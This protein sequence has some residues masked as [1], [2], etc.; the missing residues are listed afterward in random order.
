MKKV[1]IPTLAV[2]GIALLTPLGLGFIVKNKYVQLYQLASESTLPVKL[3]MVEYSQGWFSSDA[4]VQV[5]LEAPVTQE[6]EEPAHQLKNYQFELKQ[7]IYHGPII[8]QGINRITFALAL[9]DIIINQADLKLDLMT[10]LHYNNSASIH[11]E[12]PRVAETI[13]PERGWKFAMQAL[14][15]NL[16][17]NAQVTHA[18][19]KIDLTS[20]DLILKDSEQHF[21]NARFI[22]NID[23]DQLNLWHGKR[24]LTIATMS[25]D[26]EANEQL[27]VQ[28]VTL[29]LHDLS[30]NNKFSTTLYAN[31]AD[32]KLDDTD[33]GSQQVSLHVDNVDANALNKI[34]TK[35]AEL[36]KK[37]LPTSAMVLE[38]FPLVTELVEKGFSIQVSPLALNT[39]WGAIT[40]ELSL[41]IPENN[42]TNPS[43][44]ALLN[45]IT[46]DA[47]IKFPASLLQDLLVM[48]Y[49]NN[50]TP[51]TPPLNA[52]AKAAAIDDIKR[53]QL[54]GWLLA[55][56]DQFTAQ[57][58]FKENQLQINGKMMK[59]PALSI[60]AATHEPDKVMH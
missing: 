15:G 40:G 9:S 32:V 29:G 7:K 36:E 49:Q 44:D 12:C 59:I 26:T 60:S 1:V 48:R 38:L 52:D 28:G 54:A 16:K 25:F 50:N 33:Y 41:N 30:I 47:K 35:A 11:F 3:Q 19:G 21:K 13:D 18:E 27:A 31:I 45:N 42:Q 5:T 4:I 34:G 17:I 46:A 37:N 56:G 58:T 8:F 57:L 22:Y 51:V 39:S 14:S 20:L 55:D 43:L 6:F 2:V 10:V 23:K 24:D 53:W